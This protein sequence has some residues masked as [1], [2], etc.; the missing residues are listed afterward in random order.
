[1]SAAALLVLLSSVGQAAV[2]DFAGERY[3]LAF[4]QDNKQTLTQEFLRPGETLENWQ[5][6]IG[7][8]HFRAAGAL[9]DVL[10][11]YLKVVRPSFLV[12]AQFF[13]RAEGNQNEVL[14]IMQLAPPDRSYIE[15]NV[16]R[17][18]ELP[19]GR[20][21]VGYQFAWKDTSR[22]G[23]ASKEFLAKHQQAWIDE[24]GAWDF[25][26]KRAQ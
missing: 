16:H 13:S 2:L 24:L 5:R 10:P 3:L 18:V 9:R 21:V 12:P 19:D 22:S 11:E 14:L 17:F 15:H 25:L 20:G 6:L 8:R 23:V 1:M 26:P 7:V 4:N